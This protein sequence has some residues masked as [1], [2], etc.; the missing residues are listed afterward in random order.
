MLTSVEILLVEDNPNDAELSC[1]TLRKNHFDNI[2][3]AGD[4]EQA[5]DFIFGRGVYSQRDINDRPGLILLDLKLPKVD[6]LEVLKHLKSD[7]RTRSI[8]VIILTSSVAERDIM[9]TYALGGNGYIAKP[10]DFNQFTEALQ[11]L[12]LMG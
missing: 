8:P 7:A 11:Q 2:K 4:G 9:Q 12:G 6:G 3:I 10:L 5:L 1:L